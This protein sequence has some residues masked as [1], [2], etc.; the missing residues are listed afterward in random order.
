MFI[1][2][3][4]SRNDVIYNSYQQKKQDW[5]FVNPRTSIEQKSTKKIYNY[6]TTEREREVIG[7]QLKKRHNMVDYLSLSGRPVNL[8][9][10]HMT[11][12]NGASISYVEGFMAAVMPTMTAG[13]P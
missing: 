10:P 6:T 9:G 8:N 12:F 7:E 2:F 3:I 4:Y 1:V 13:I 11:S 5:P